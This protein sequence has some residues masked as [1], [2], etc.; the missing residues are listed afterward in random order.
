MRAVESRA[1]GGGP[2]LAGRGHALERPGSPPHP[3][4]LERVADMLHRFAAARLFVVDDNSSNIALLQA[5]LTRAGIV[6]V[7][8]ETDGRQVLPRLPEVHPDLLILDLHMPHLDGFAVL[9]QVR[10]FSVSDYL[11]V[12]VITADTTASASERALGEGAQDFVTKPFSNSEVVLRVRNLLE[13]RFLYAAL[14]S[15][16]TLGGTTGEVMQQ[17]AS[18]AVELTAADYA[19]IAVPADP[20]TAQITDLRVAVCIG[21]ADRTIIGRTI[22]A[23]STT[24]AVFLDRVPRKVAELDLPIGKNSAAGTGPALACPLGTGEGISAVLLTA[25][26]PGAATFDGHDLKLLATFADQ[27]GL[28]L[29]RAEHQHAQHEL[30]I[31]ADRDRIARDLHDHVIQRLFAVGL[32]MRTTGRRADQPQVAERIAE[33]MSQLNE[34]IHDIRSTIFELEDDPAKTFG[35]RAALAD[36]ITAMTGDAALHTS[37][38]MTGPVDLLPADVAGHAQAV[39]REA[40]ANAVRHSGA[41]ELTILISVGDDVVVIDVTDD[42][43]GIPDVPGRNSGIRNLHQR[44]RAVGGTFSVARA[45]GGGT[46]VLWTA[47]LH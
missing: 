10:Q 41:S 43:I 26:A 8:T 37:V 42:G 6:N 20:D 33:H 35:V 23:G 22:P 15:S 14:R 39:V 36:T 24:G 4:F 46:R 21:S 5:V 1:P 2:N 12:L 30:A 47:P 9:E 13:T 32:A 18:R 45:D 28:G 25:R 19:L 44:A 29:Q 16:T 11:P 3:T 7:F 17:I 27:A 38:Q 34:V 40:T 31:L